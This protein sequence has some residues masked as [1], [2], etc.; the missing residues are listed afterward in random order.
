VTYSEGIAVGYRWYDQQ[1]IQPLFPF[2]HGLSYT[3]FE[4]SQLSVKRRGGGVDVTFTL[5]NAG[6]RKGAE[7]AQVYIGPPAAAPVEFAP[8]S[9]AGFARIELAPGQSRQVSI[10]IDARAL[11]YWST[12]THAWAMPKGSREIY[13]GSSS[14][15]IRLQGAIPAGV[16]EE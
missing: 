15:D 9:L 14:R 1:S 4:Y 7:V 8:K 3:R 6:A 2:G 11:S 5:R 12:A 13:L 10:H 16:S